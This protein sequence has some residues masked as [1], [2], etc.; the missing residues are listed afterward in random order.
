MP[1]DSQPG[2]GPAANYSAARA[3]PA[4][5]PAA[6]SRTAPH[7]GPQPAR[8]RSA[9]RS[10]AGPTTGN[11]TPALHPT[12]RNLPSASR[13]A[14]LIQPANRAVANRRPVPV[15][16]ATRAVARNPLR[17]LPPSP[18]GPAR[19]AMVVRLRSCG[20]HLGRVGNRRRGCPG[21][22]TSLCRPRRSGAGSAQRVPPL[23][24]VGGPRPVRVF[25][26][27]RCRTPGSC[28]SPPRP[29]SR[30]GDTKAPSPTP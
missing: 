21:T 2:P 5:T 27:P 28:R 1:A 24:G 12:A 11:P 17:H 10:Q 30:G 19:R 23:H 18:L 15:L 16:T 14:G 6:R 3:Q 22:R 25:R 8:N 20:G 26:R 7:P 4:R 13:S 29:G 9:A